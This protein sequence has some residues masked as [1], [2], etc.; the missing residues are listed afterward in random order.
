MRVS[1]WLGLVL[2]AG[3]CSFD[4]PGVAIDGG[5]SDARDAGPDAAS[6]DDDND[7]VLNPVDNCR[8]VA[9]LNQHDE[10]GDGDGDVCDN[11]PTVGNADQ[12][13]LGETNVGQAIDEAGDACDPF[14]AIAGNDLVFF[15]GF[16]TDDPLWRST[17]GVWVVAGDAVT[18]T[19]PLS[20]S[21]YYYAG[22][23]HGDVVVDVT[24][25]VTAVPANGFGIGSLAQW[26]IGPN[27][28][29][30]YMCQLADFPS[31]PI[32]VA[33]FA[34][35]GAAAWDQLERTQH[36]ALTPAVTPA[37]AWTLRHA[38][39]GAARSCAATD[40]S[41]FTIDTP[42]HLHVDVP[43]GR[44]GFRSGY[45]SMQFENIVVYS[46]AGS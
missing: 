13:N 19:D 45:A 14:P 27:D 44:F 34:L 11:C 31:A 5:G 12:A 15:D 28:G 22:D 25:R 9:N 36:S 26:D 40:S 20:R 39:I 21:H 43:S 32:E 33:E 3:A 2:V 46:V 7:G 37:S 35:I 24:A 30:G 23:P 1:P 8:A 42:P 41:G 29:V 38:A 6:V 16:D 10:D 4:A 18:Q 17:G